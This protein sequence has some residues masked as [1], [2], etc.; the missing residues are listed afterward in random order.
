MTYDLKCFK[1]VEDFLDLTGREFLH[2][3]LVILQF[4]GG[5]TLS[6]DLVD[7]EAFNPFPLDRNNG[8][9]W[10]TQLQSLGSNDHITFPLHQGRIHRYTS[11]SPKKDNGD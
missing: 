6:T 11:K 3:V 9:I 8:A 5:E 7:T 1:S 4:D 10:K 2:E